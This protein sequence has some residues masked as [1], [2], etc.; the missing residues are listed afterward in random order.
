MHAYECMCTC[1]PLP[2]N[3]SFYRQIASYQPGVLVIIEYRL[4]MK[5]DHRPVKNLNWGTFNYASHALLL[6]SCNYYVCVSV[7]MCVHVC[8]CACTRVSVRVRCVYMSARVCVCMSVCAC[9]VC[10]CVHVLCVHVLC[11]CVCACV[12]CIYHTLHVRGQVCMRA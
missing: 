5:G 11:V 8:A 3:Q 12:L 7:C 4:M 6:R 2:S 10:V 1:W 9:V